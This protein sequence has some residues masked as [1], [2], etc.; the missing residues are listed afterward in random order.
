MSRQLLFGLA[1]STL[2]LVNLVTLAANVALK[3]TAAGAG[4]GYGERY[5]DRDFQRAIEHVIEGGKADSGGSISCRRRRLT[6]GTA[7]R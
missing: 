6:D 1:M 5:R 3:A 4:M 7:R 2:P